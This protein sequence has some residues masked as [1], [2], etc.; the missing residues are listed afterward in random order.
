MTQRGEYENWEPPSAYE[1]GEERN[2]SSAEFS[3][4]SVSGA[5]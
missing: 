1:E 5:F 2:G 4:L 3:Q